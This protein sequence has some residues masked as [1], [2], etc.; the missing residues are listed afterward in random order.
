LKN[1]DRSVG[2]SIAT[3]YGLDGRDSISGK[4]KRFFLFFTTSSPLSNEYPRI[5]ARR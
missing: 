4:D 2:K 1:R 5:F 3:G